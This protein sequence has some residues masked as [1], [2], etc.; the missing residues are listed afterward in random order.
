MKRICLMAV[1]AL[2][3][4]GCSVGRVAPQAAL[5]DL[6]PEPTASVQLPARALSSWPFRPRLR[7]AI[8]E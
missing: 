8:R 5:F 6:G 3:L 7:S 1:L 2:V 4:G